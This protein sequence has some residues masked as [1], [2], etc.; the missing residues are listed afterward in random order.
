MDEFYSKF[1]LSDSSDI[2]Y[3]PLEIQKKGAH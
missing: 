2:D 1:K 3:D